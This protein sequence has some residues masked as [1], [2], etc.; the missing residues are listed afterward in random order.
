MARKKRSTKRHSK[1]R[2][3]GATAGGGLMSA[4]SIVAGAVIGRVISKK[5]E[6]KVKPALLGG[7]QIAVGYFL[8]RFVKNKFVAGIGTGM[9]VNGAVSLLQ[10]TGVIGAIGAIGEMD[11]GDTYQLSGSDTIREIAGMDD[12]ADSFGG[13][14]DAGIMSGGGSADISILAGD[15]DEEY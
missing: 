9:I 12:E 3:M 11:E 6:T 10:S 15:Y 14:Y 7:G 2:R 4:A 13:L 8:P 1:R 5:L